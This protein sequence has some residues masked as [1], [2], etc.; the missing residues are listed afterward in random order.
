M[1]AR[2]YVAALNR[3]EV[4]A[5]ASLEDEGVTEL[6][7][8]EVIAATAAGRA[9]ISAAEAHALL[10]V[11]MRKRRREGQVTWW[12]RWRWPVLPLAGAA[13]AL[14]VIL[15]FVLRASPEETL[16]GSAA[17]ASLIVLTQVP[18]E[19][20]VEVVGRALQLPPGAA[21]RLVLRQSGSSF[22]ALYE[23][24]EL[25][26]A[27]ELWR[28]TEALVAGDTAL[29]PNGGHDGLVPERGTSNFW[30]VISPHP[31]P[32]RPE[33]CRGCGIERLTMTR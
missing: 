13:A 4:P 7:A 32:V 31:I 2:D 22:V 8:A 3:G 33:E 19:A 16:K 11:A 14:V 28:S 21:V 25:A 6:S 1:K 18:G 5:S 30:V 24:P 15:S 29:G 10:D 17:H 20:P 12:S 26:T 27:R 9:A 23:G